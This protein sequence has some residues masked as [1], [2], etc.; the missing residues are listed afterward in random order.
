ML[1]AAARRAAPRF[2]RTT[3]HLPYRVTGAFPSEMLALIGA[4]EAMHATHLIESG[5]ASG[6]S[7]EMLASYFSDHQYPLSITTID[8]GLL[9]GS[10]QNNATRRR[11]ERYANVE[12]MLADSRSMIPRLLDALPVEA[13]AVVF[14][15]G[16]KAEAGK[17]LA[18]LALRHPRVALVSLHDAAPF[19]NVQFH[20]S[21]RNHPEHLLLTSD[22]HFRR[23]FGDLDER[24]NVP[25]TLERA[26]R[27]GPASG[28]TGLANLV[29][30]GN[31]LWLAG[32]TKLRGGPPVHIALGTDDRGVAGLLAVI[33]STLK[34]TAERSRLVFHVLVASPSRS[35]VER[36]L[37]ALA[38]QLNGARLD[39]IALQPEASSSAAMLLEQ[40]RLRLPELLP[41]VRKVLYLDVDTLMLADPA[42]S[43]PAG[44]FERRRFPCRRPNPLLAL[45]SYPCTSIP[46]D[47]SG[48]CSLRRQE[49][50]QGDRRRASAKVIAA[51][52]Q[53]DRGCSD[54]AGALGV[55][56]DRVVV[57]RGRNA[58]AARHVARGGAHAASP[59]LFE[60]AKR[61]GISRSARNVDAQRHPEC[62]LPLLSK[63]EPWPLRHREDPSAVER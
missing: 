4:I 12:C 43:M 49:S 1:V 11:L 59:G 46:C 26:H 56:I 9:Y 37:L 42:P 40:A 63:R 21:L 6:V 7:T 25:A 61:S 14:V 31:G 48:R 50:R 29:R 18:L 3:A 10:A 20:A 2:L 23:A 57:Q 16:P 51:E 38:S 34:A 62:A 33:R 44:D 22:A 24:A 52:H 45:P 28:A 39:V 58:A 8:S 13:R 5:T 53:S 32:R 35:L 41:R 55:A 19:W 47:G 15:D 30:F 54:G 17:D 60:Q 27:A 36:Q